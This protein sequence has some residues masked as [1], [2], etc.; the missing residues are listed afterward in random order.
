MRRTLLFL[1]LTISLGSV[2]Q[3][4]KGVFVGVTKSGL[5]SP[6]WFLSLPLEFLTQ[7]PMG[8]T[9]RFNQY[10]IEA[11]YQFNSKIRTALDLSLWNS[12]ADR[13]ITTYQLGLS[14]SHRLIEQA[15]V[16]PKLRYRAG[17]V[18]YSNETESLE[19]YVGIDILAS[20]VFDKI[21]IDLGGNLNYI[22]SYPNG[23]GIGAGYTL[24]LSYL[25]PYISKS[26]L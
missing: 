13:E 10:G 24:S 4:Q 16:S 18:L 22:S 26:K 5:V 3:E 6:V 23:F 7:I 15:K 20:V 25:I 1:L 11:G 9:T 2:A 21:T 14:I 19:A 17:T 12:K 8:E